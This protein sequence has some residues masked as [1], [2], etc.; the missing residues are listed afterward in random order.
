MGNKK[1]K[2]DQVPFVTYDGVEY[3]LIT[4]MTHK[5]YYLAERYT[6]T[7]VQNLGAYTTGLLLAFFTL[8]RAGHE[9]DWDEWLDQDIDIKN[10]D[11][12]F[13]EDGDATS[14]SAKTVQ[15]ENDGDQ[16]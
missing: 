1:K 12:P 7:S 9:L 11:V 14:G 16:D 5:E 13:T 6:Q 4:E 3:P 2:P 15:P 10:V 8:R